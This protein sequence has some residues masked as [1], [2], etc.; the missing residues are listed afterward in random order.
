MD[1]DWFQDLIKFNMN[2]EAKT[3]IAIFGIFTNGIYPIHWTQPW[4]IRTSTIA[5]LGYQ[6]TKARES[7]NRNRD[8]DSSRNRPLAGEFVSSGELTFCH[9]KSQF[10][11]GKST[12][13]GHFP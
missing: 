5:D 8:T 9:G 2:M 11:M 13:N 7:S 10:F 1:I 3:N 6:A 12:I 4:N